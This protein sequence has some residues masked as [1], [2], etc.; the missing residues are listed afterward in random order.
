MGYKEEALEILKESIVI[1][2]HSDMPVDVAQKRKEG[3]KRVI[4]NIHL[5]RLK[6][7]GVNGLVCAL[8]VETKY[9]PERSLKRA[10]E[11]L[12]H[13]LA[14]IDESSNVKLCLTATDIEKTIRNGKLGILLSFEGAEPIGTDLSILDIFYRL[15]VRWV[16]L[17]WNHRNQVGDGIYESRTNG[18]LTNFG[19]ELV[20]RLN[21]LSI[22][23]DLAHASEATFYDAID[24][25][26]DPVI[27]SHANA[28]AVYDHPRN[29]TDDQIRAVKDNGGLIGVTFYPGIVDKEKPSLEKV[30]QHFTHIVELAGIKHVMF[31]ADFADYIAWSPE[32]VGPNF[33]K[34][35]Y[36][37][38][39]KDVTEFPN[40]VEGLLRLGYSEKEIKG[41]LGENLLHLLRKIL[42]A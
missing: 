30:L 40:F 37:N 11:L 29:L 25:S 9:K 31:G 20:E 24:V 13:T 8:Y 4:E 2:G 33:K 15:G 17:T 10:L 19:V 38:G 16:G 6:K 1:D 27:V 26:K 28:K 12:G 42:G 23:V 39:L 3:V 7:G 34:H 35:P 36:T 22:V 21:K 5:P 32:E 14:D 41:V 18:G